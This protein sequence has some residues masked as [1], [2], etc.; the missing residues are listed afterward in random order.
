[1]RFS[2]ITRQGLLLLIL[3][4][5]LAVALALCDAW[6]WSLP[7]LLLAFFTVYLYRDLPRRIP[8]K[9]NAL[10]SPLDGTVLAVET[11]LDPYVEREAIRIEAVTHWNG[12]FVLR[13]P[14]EGKV[15]EQ[16]FSPASKGVDGRPVP[17]MMA[18]WIRSDEE[19][20]L[21]MV[22][23]P[24][25]HRPGMSCRAHA[26]DRVGQ[27]RRCGFIPLGA[28]IEVFLPVNSRVQIQAGQKVSAGDTILAQLVRT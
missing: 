18:M 23:T 20:D 28:R 1:M 10:V 13:S 3:W 16:W 14:M 11:A 24:R 22:V 21:V 7:A 25:S 26:G 8:P 2:I 5:V 9:P 17:P 15:L 6:P 19:D 27:G 4:L 12:P